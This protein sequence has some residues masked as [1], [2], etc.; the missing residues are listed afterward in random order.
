MKLDN[1]KIALIAALGI[2]VLLIGGLYLFRFQQT[3]KLPPLPPF[4]K[5]V[6]NFEEVKADSALNSLWIK[7]GLFTAEGV[8]I[9]R[10]DNIQIMYS[11]NMSDTLVY[12]V[13][14][15][16]P[17]EYWLFKVKDDIVSNELLKAKVTKAAPYYYE[18]FVAN[19]SNEKRA[20]SYQLRK[21][22]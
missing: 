18:C 22:K 1:N 12:K 9:E 17:W 11:E 15:K 7:E 6:K 10:K 8:T 16:N 2:T 5:Q 13:I 20:I 21:L 19:A 3:E 4:Q 14:W